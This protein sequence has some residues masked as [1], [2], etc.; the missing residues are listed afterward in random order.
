MS[1]SFTVK[2]EVIASVLRTNCRIG[3][4]FKLDK[5]KKIPEQEPSHE[6][7]VAIWDTGAS[8]TVINKNVAE[9]LGLEPISTTTIQTANGSV[10]AS[11]YC[12]CLILPHQVGISTMEVSEANLGN[13]DVLIGMDVIAQGDFAITNNN[14]K[15]MMSFRIPSL[16]HIDF[17]AGPTGDNLSSPVQSKNSLCHCGSGKK[18]KRCHGAK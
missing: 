13:I 7:F 17:V 16:E 14:G 2:H 15:T 18:F 10:D 8:R 5:S 3:K 11:V 4:A 1:K 6:Q 12:I 9:K